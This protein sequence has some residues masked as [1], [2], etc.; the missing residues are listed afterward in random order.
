MLISSLAIT[1]FASLSRPICG[2]RYNTLIITLPGSTKA[3]KENLGSII[4]VLPHALELCT[5]RDTGGKHS[6]YDLSKKSRCGC[7][8]QVN[9]DNG[10]NGVSDSLDISGIYI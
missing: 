2:I 3:C 8:D 6:R 5:G 7:G 9:G 10:G 1:K 4:D